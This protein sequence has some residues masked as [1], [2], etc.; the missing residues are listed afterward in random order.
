MSLAVSVLMMDEFD[1]VCSHCAGGV[2]SNFVFQILLSI[3]L[4]ITESNE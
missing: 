1:Q 4:R 2:I 3:R